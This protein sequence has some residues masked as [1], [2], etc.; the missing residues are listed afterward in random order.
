[1]G[2]IPSDFPARP[3][4]PPLETVGT[5]WTGSIKNTYTRAAFFSVGVRIIIG[6]AASLNLPENLS[7]LSHPSHKR[8]GGPLGLRGRHRC[9][10]LAIGLAGNVTA[11]VAVAGNGETGVLK[12]GSLNG[13]RRSTL[14][15]VAVRILRSS[16]NA[17][18][19]RQKHRDPPIRLFVS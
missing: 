11:Q 15:V 12:A 10:I 7:N 14:A 18:R 16:A 5:D 4:F 19:G 2:C 6:V 3:P 8:V 13:T 1:M 9:G 17:D